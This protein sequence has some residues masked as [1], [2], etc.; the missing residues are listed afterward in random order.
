MEKIKQLGLRIKENAKSWWAWMRMHKSAETPNHIS[1]EN[2]VE[3]IP[4]ALTNP[5]AEATMLPADAMITPPER[6]VKLTP[7][8]YLKRSV[9]RFIT[10]LSEE[11]K[12]GLAE[13]LLNCT[14]KQR[15]DIIYVLPKLSEN[16]AKLLVEKLG[17]QRQYP[18]NMESKGTKAPK[19][20]VK[21][22]EKFKEEFGL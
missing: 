8:E 20:W 11:E 17:V 10:D 6:E 14:D 12:L 9:V 5:I 2:K 3:P 4:E 1:T 16:S 7:A 19:V 15:R 22:A 21:R 13:I 18:M